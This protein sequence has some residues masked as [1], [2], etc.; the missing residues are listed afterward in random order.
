L[1]VGPVP[2]GFQVLPRR[3]VVE[4]TFVWLGRW[5]R[6]SKGYEYLPTTSACVIELA[7]IC[8]M[9]CQL[10][11]SET[12]CLLRNALVSWECRLSSR[13]GW[14]EASGTGSGVNQDML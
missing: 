2:R 6:T 8:L 10:A 14:S 1:E 3:W 12:M 13:M 11:E 4:R 5:R 7:M 9:L